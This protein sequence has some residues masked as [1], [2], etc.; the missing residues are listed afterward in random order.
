MSDIAMHISADHPSFAGHFPG[1][2]ITPGVV[3][4][5]EAMHAIAHELQLELQTCRINSVKFL[6]PVLPGAQL[7][8]HY[9]IGANGNIRFD[10]KDDQRIAATGVLH[11]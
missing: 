2:P 7:S 8:V 4:L 11:V 1:M 10:I 3:L 5:D 9:D 6:H